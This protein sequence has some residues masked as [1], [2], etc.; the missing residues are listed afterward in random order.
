MKLASAL[1]VG[2]VR[3]RRHAPRAHTFAYPLFLT[4]LDLDELDRAFGSH[5]LWSTRRPALAR[6]DRRDYYGDPTVPLDRAVR[7]LVRERTDSAPEGPVRLL[8]HLRMFGVA[9][10]PVSFYY[11]YARDGVT[12]EAIVAEVSNTPW[13]ERHRYVLDARGRGG[14]LEFATRKSFHVSPFLPMELEYRF[15][16]S[17]PGE[18]LTV[19]ME[20]HGPDGRVFDATLSLE[21]RE[22]TG[23][24]LATTL[25]RHP[26]MTLQVLAAIYWEAFRLWLK[27]IPYHPHPRDA[28]PARTRSTA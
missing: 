17:V 19:H 23:A 5:P 12:I 24:T 2:R 9:F 7:D 8:T 16:F 27:R 4:W 14:K 20:D 10:N 18:R 22:I 25:L 6:F 15:R 21:R 3:H 1:Y 28:A 11:C 26:F 13:N